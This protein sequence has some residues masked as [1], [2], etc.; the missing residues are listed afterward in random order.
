MKKKHEEIVQS[1]KKFAEAAYDML[2]MGQIPEFMVPQQQAQ[3][4]VILFFKKS[5]ISKQA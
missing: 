2:R 1:A 5:R 4:Q 3:F